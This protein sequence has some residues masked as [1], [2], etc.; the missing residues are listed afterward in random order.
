M[1]VLPMTS[2]TELD[3]EAENGEIANHA[4]EAELGIQLGAGSHRQHGHILRSGGRTDHRPL[5][6]LLPFS[7]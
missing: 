6:T 4:A 2:R 3:A 7:V 5:W 1:T